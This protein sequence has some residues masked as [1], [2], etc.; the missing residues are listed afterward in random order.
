M[1]EIST[2]SEA[3]TWISPA[4]PC[5]RVCASSREPPVSETASAVM[6][7]LPPDP[8]APNSTVVLMLLLFASATEP[9]IALIVTLPPFP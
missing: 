4:S 5:P 6:S 3:L 2:R 1:P 9:L 7:M 8:V